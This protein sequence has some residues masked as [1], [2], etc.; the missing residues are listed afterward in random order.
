M[1]DE[2]KLQRMACEFVRQITALECTCTRHDMEQHRVLDAGAHDGRQSARTQ[3]YLQNGTA[4][5]F[6]ESNDSKHTDDL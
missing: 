5:I 3:Q 2:K 6:E 4:G 1:R